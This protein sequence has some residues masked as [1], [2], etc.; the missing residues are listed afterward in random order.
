MP[1]NLRRS[2]STFQNGLGELPSAKK[3]QAT[4]LPVRLGSA[5]RL[6]DGLF[7]VDDRLQECEIIWS[8]RKAAVDSG[9]ERE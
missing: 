5:E 8:A 3:A 1:P 6:R 7:L 2:G 9:R 4:R